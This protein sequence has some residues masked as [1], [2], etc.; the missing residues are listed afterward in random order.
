[1]Q[2]SLTFADLKA[3]HARIRDHVLRTPV[4]QRAH[5]GAELLCK[6]ESLQPIGAFKLRGAFNKLLTLPEGTA[7]VVTHSSGNFAQALSLA[8][9]TLHLFTIPQSLL[10]V[11][12]SFKVPSLLKQQTKVL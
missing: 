5:N 12:I 1:M 3:A 7:G 9:K 6:P 4:L 11:E 2:Q 10:N 8:A